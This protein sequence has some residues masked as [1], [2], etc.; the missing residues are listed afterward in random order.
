MSGLASNYHELDTDI[1][2]SALRLSEYDFETDIDVNILGHIFEHSL[3]EIENVQ[4]EIKGEEVDG[5]KIIIDKTVNLDN[6]VFS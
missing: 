2:L 6:V 1:L 4:A 5:Q 3:G